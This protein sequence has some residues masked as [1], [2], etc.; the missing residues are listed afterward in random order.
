MRACSVR[1]GS[2]WVLAEGH[3]V[4]RWRGEVVGFSERISWKGEGLIRLEGEALTFTPVQD[5]VGLVESQRS[6]GAR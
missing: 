3:D 5:P 4:I 1:R 6:G 2:R